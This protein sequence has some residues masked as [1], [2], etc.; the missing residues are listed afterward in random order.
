[1][2]VLMG[3]CSYIRSKLLILYVPITIAHSAFDIKT[4]HKCLL[5][6]IFHVEHNHGA[7]HRRSGVDSSSLGFNSGEA[8]S[9]T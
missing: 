5:Q 7:N 4:L 1:V 2:V 8:S 3:D 6:Y 9:E